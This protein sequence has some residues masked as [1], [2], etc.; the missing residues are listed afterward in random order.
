MHLLAPE[1]KLKEE[2]EAK[3]GEAIKQHQRASKDGEHKQCIDKTRSRPKTVLLRGTTM[4]HAM[5]T[6]P[7]D[8]KYL[9][10]QT[11]RTCQMEKKAGVSGR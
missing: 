6:I 9:R 7:T 10:D 1:P 5:T 8:D 2:A 3:K 11:T 4:T